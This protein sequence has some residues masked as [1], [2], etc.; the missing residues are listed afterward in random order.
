MNTAD[1]LW[2]ILHEKEISLRQLSNGADIPYST[3][4]S[5][6]KTP[7]NSRVCTI[8]KLCDYLQISM[9]DLFGRSAQDSEDAEIEEE[10]RLFREFLRYKR[11]KLWAEHK[12]QE[13]DQ[14]IKTAAMDGEG[15]Y[16]LAMLAKAFL[17]EPDEK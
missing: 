4:V 15:K 6:V 16:A 13:L 10:V 1:R 8:L 9:D 11:R 12:D 7:E 3:L 2:G 14:Y 5:A 17:G